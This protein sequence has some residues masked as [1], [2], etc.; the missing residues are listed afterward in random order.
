MNEKLT[1]LIVPF[2]K[3]DHSMHVTKVHIMNKKSANGPGLPFLT[4]GHI[5]DRTN[6]DPEQIYMRFCCILVMFVVCYYTSLYC[7]Q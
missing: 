5:I 3:A 6:T 1:S 4:V 2:Y 7:T